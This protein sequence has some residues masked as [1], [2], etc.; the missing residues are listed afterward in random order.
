MMC[1]ITAAM[2]QKE[3]KILELTRVSLAADRKKQKD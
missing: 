3:L 2:E 1:S